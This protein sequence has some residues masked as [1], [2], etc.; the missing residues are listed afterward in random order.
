MCPIDT[1]TH[2]DYSLIEWWTLSDASSSHVMW[3]NLSA[4]SLIERTQLNNDDSRIGVQ[5]ELLIKDEES[6][7]MV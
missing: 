3:K 2:L 6:H 1:W 7:P 4:S 5:S